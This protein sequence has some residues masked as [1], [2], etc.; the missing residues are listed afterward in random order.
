MIYGCDRKF[1]IYVIGN[2]RNLNVVSS[3][4]VDPVYDKEKYYREIHFDYE[5]DIQTEDA[6]VNEGCL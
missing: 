6:A 1:S 3:Q 4:L 2:L 5:P